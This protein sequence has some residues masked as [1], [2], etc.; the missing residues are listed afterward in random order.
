MDRENRVGDAR[1]QVAVER[2]FEIIGEAPN[3]L[4]RSHPEIADRIPPLREGI[5]FHN[6]LIHG[7]SIVIPDRVRDYAEHDLSELR[8]MAQEL[9]A[10]SGPPEE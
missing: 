3:R 8:K 7:N 10:A 9:L 1:T 4:Q 6:L 5:G 2:R